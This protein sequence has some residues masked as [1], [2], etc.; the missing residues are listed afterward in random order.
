MNQAIQ[1]NTVADEFLAQTRNG[2]TCWALGKGLVMDRKGKVGQ[3]PT[4]ILKQ[5]YLDIRAMSL[6]HVP[7]GSL[8]PQWG[9]TLD[10][11]GGT[12]H[13]RE[14]VALGG[15][16]DRGNVLAAS[17]STIGTRNG[18][19]FN[20]SERTTTK[21]DYEFDRLFLAGKSRVTADLGKAMGKFLV[22]A[23]DDLT[24]FGPSV[25]RNV[26]VAVGIRGRIW[27]S[28]FLDQLQL[29]STQSIREVE[30]ASR[31][32]VDSMAGVVGLQA[33][34]LADFHFK[35]LYQETMKQVTD[36]YNSK[37]QTRYP[38]IDAILLAN[39]DLKRFKLIFGGT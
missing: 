9:L 16:V 27:T 3:F 7:L 4:Y 36:F 5:G 19:I 17:G 21:V 6:S 29:D 37:N 15:T 20:G 34:E 31:S 14:V 2:I 11:Q 38:D 23:N 13:G 24:S 1:N 39:R 32:V 22:I 12:V 18:I 28:L 25:L 10:V 8:I 33:V 26:D 35:Q 30:N